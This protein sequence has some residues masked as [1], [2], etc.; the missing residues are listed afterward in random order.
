MNKWILIFL[1]CSAGFCFAANVSIKG[2]SL[3]SKFPIND[4]RNPDCP[5]HKQQHLADLEYRKSQGLKSEKTKVTPQVY[6]VNSSRSKQRLL[7]RK[8]KPFMAKIVY[9]NYAKLNALRRSIIKHVLN[10]DD[11]FSFF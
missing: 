7:S 9:R 11:C 3:K 8:N 5:C 1:F 6:S 10:V 4:P 2:D